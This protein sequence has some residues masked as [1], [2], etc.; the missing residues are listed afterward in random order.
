[1]TPQI[2]RLGEDPEV[3]AAVY[4]FI[5]LLP[6]ADGYQDIREASERLRRVVCARGVGLFLE[7]SPGSPSRREIRAISGGEP[8]RKW[9]AKQSLSAVEAAYTRLSS[10]DAPPTPF[11]RTWGE[12]SIDAALLTQSPQRGQPLGMFFVVGAQ[13]T[14]FLAEGNAGQ[15]QF[16]VV[17]LVDTLTA[18]VEKS[19]A[20]L[21][22]LLTPTPDRTAMFHSHLGENNPIGSADWVRYLST[23]LEDVRLILRWVLPVGTLKEFC[24]V[25]TVLANLTIWTEDQFRL[26]KGGAPL[27]VQGER[28]IANLANDLSQAWDHLHSAWL[29]SLAD[30]VHSGFGKRRWSKLGDTL[31]SLSRWLA[32]PPSRW[33]GG[34]PADV[35]PAAN[36]HFHLSRAGARHCFASEFANLARHTSCLIEPQTDLTR[37]SLGTYFLSQALNFGPARAAF[38]TSPAPSDEDMRNAVTGIARVAHHLLADFPLDRQ[39]ISSLIWLLSEYAHNELGIPA[40]IDLRAHLLLAAREEPALHAL[41][42]Y[43]RNH[44]FHALEVCFLGHLLLDLELEPARPLWKLVS[45]R[46]PG[47]PDRAGV[48]RLWYLASLLHD[49]GYAVEVAKGLCKLTRTFGKDDPLA[50]LAAGVESAMRDVTSQLVAKEYLGYTAADNPGEDHGVVCA[51][52]LQRMLDEIEKRDPSFKPTA[53]LPAIKAVGFHNSR[54]HRISFMEEPLAFLLVLCDTVQDWNR[55]HLP[56]STAPI[57]IMAWLMDRKPDDS[58]NPEAI[59]RVTLQ[60]AVKRNVYR[61]LEPY[62][63]GMTLSYRDDIHHDNGVFN[64]WMDASC[65]LQRLDMT[66]C[67]FEVDLTFRTPTHPDR[68]EPQRR[69]TNMYRLRD[70]VREAH[71]TFIE[72]WFPTHSVSPSDT[73]TTNGAVEHSIIE[74]GAQEE[75]TLHVRRL[76][77]LRPILKDISDIRTALARWRHYSDD[78]VFEE[79]Y[80]VP[81]QL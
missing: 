1:M 38:W 36:P 4:S 60:A 42:A 27:S 56:Y 19:L 35:S 13:P 67:P 68:T 34:F 12:T 63:I 65:N 78:L 31:L 14:Q 16:P 17:P 55:P 52:H 23:S 44:F 28:R 47:K 29:R 5:R 18:C 80:G 79:E 61:T 30:S 24:Q 32:A 33:H 43:Y 40:Q 20:R 64:L 22:L 25:S 72:R 57:Q 50:A 10:S 54:K 53:F 69:T 9:L 3:V 37:K 48:L 49:V 2:S 66:N 15:A 75:L 6:P 59:H 21:A 76:G 46:V 73:R 81:D 39:T 71:L 11:L 62:K 77:E 51:R 74:N 26:L 8:F 70:A 58:P 41:K 7:R 45:S